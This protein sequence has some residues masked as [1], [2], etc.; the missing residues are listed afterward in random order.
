M[1]VPVNQLERFQT[2]QSNCDHSKLTEKHGKLNM[3]FCNKLMHVTAANHGV[4][5]MQIADQL[6][7][8]SYA[9]IDWLEV[10]RGV[11]AALKRINRL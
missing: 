1:I 11:T 2:V 6:K 5:T 4:T 7:E 10:D 8:Q 3:C 9:K